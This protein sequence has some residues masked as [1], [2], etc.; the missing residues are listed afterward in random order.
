MRGAASCSGMMDVYL[1]FSTIQFY[2]SPVI[3]EVIHK[4]I[5]RERSH[6]SPMEGFV[7]RFSDRSVVGVAGVVGLR[8]S[9]LESIL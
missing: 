5:H 8:G 3:H 9:R 4:L 2:L 6:N 7:G 1:Q